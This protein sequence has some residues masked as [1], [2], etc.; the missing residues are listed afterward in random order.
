MFRSCCCQ[1]ICHFITHDIL[2]TWHSYQLNPVMFGPVVAR[3]AARKSLPAISL[4]LVVE[5][6]GFLSCCTVSWHH[7][8]IRYPTQYNRISETTGWCMPTV[9]LH[10][11]WE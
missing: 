2:M 8:M 10:S 1:L 11:N 5:Q 9:T 4:I 7:C 6:S 3:R